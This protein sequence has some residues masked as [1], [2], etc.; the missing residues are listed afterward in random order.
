MADRRR[1]STDGGVD[2][3]TVTRSEA[4]APIWTTSFTLASAVSFFLSAMFFLLMIT[5][6]GYTGERFEASVAVG[7]L[8]ASIFVVGAVLGRPFAGRYLDAMGRRPMLIASLALTLAAC[9]VYPAV[10]TIGQLMA[11]RLVQGMGFGVAHTAISASVM[12]LIPRARRAEGTGYFTMSGTMAAALAPLVALAAV[13]LGG[14]AAIFTVS[15]FLSGAAVLCAVLL[16]LPGPVTEGPDRPARRR[17]AALFVEPTAL[18]I[19]FVILL[20]GVAVSGLMAF[21]GVYAVDR[22]LEWAGSAFFVLYSVAML[23]SRVGMGRVHDTRGDNA[24][25]L[26]AFAALAAGLA[27][28]AFADT[29]TLVLVAAVLCGVGAGTLLASGQVIAVA[30]VPAERIGVATSTYF[31]L[32][33]TGVGLGPLA[34]GALVAVSGFG[35][36]YLALAGV[37]VLA[38]AVYHLV[39]GRRRGSP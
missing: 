7:G 15:A 18:P 19:A 26:P 11:V 24:V 5:M 28:L 9:L 27:L 32:L 12:A 36:M 6:V 23:A 10:G 14:S 2:A 25:V 39:H 8:A 4:A 29:T 20:V 31:L 35:G 33:D 21:V 34:L 30:S 17:S 38:A 22:G 1:A 37:M 3:S 13:H 16:R